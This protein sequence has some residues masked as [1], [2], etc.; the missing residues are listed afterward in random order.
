LKLYIDWNCLIAL[1]YVINYKN[2]TII[3]SILKPMWEVY[4]FCCFLQE[5]DALF[6]FGKITEYIL[7]KLCNREQSNTER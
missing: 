7:F 1:K 5:V 3:I 4:D 2:T 6:Y